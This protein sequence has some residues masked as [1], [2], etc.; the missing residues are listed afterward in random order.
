M[1]LGFGQEP[2]SAASV[3]ESLLWIW[4]WVLRYCSFLGIFGFTP[5]IVVWA[6]APCKSC[7]F[8]EQFSL[9]APSWRCW[10]AC[11]ECWEWV[12]TLPVLLPVSPSIFRP[13]SVLIP[14]ATLDCYAQTARAGLGG[15]FLPDIPSSPSLY[16]SWESYALD[17]RV[18]DACRAYIAP[19]LSIAHVCAML[20]TTPGMLRG[21]GAQH[22]YPACEGSEP[23]DQTQL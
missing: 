9:K 7:I 10:Q 18:A 23:E 22:M 6:N 14:K 16:S 17:L 3:K 21:G 2:A 19:P 8:Q 4:S 15:W 13:C 20:T 11:L 5:G 12:R 1:P